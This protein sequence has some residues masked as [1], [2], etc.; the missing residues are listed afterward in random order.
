MV[1]NCL[2]RPNEPHGDPSLVELKGDSGI[3]GIAT[4]EGVVDGGNGIESCT[5]YS[6][7]V[8]VHVIQPRLGLQP[9][10]L[11]VG[12]LDNEVAICR[13]E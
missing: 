4:H 6:V 2:R 5:E 8:D 3:G 9:I 7:P 10:A 12:D 13:R 11:D 1:R